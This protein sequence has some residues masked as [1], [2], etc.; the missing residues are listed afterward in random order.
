MK[1]KKNIIGGFSSWNIKILDFSRKKINLICIISLLIF[2]IVCVE[3]FSITGGVN[4]SNISVKVNEFRMQTV[5]FGGGFSFFTKQL[6]KVLRG[7]CY[8]G[9]YLIVNDIFGKKANSIS[10]CKIIIFLVLPYVLLEYLTGERFYLLTIAIY[11]LILYLI[12]SKKFLKNKSNF[13]TLIFLCL[14][15]VILVNI[16]S[17]SRSIVGRGGSTS[18]L[19]YL[20]SYFGN[21]VL[22]F[23]YWTKNFSIETLN[24]GLTTFSGIC[25]LLGDFGFVDSSKYIA[26]AYDF[27]YLDDTWNSIGNVYSC[28][29]YYL[30]DFGLAGIVIYPIIIALISGYLYYRKEGDKHAIS[31]KVLIYCLCGASLFLEG[32]CAGFLGNLV[33]IDFIVNFIII[34]FT[35]NYLSGT[36]PFRVKIIA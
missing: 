14:C 22:I 23:D 25:D 20:G 1:N 10:I 31:N 4:L 30:R 21:V 29:G 34:T 11:A 18:A 13:K 9:I 8:V 36:L 26:T 27:V 32:Y 12:F 3:Y 24:Y 19:T 6:I 15:F 16:F 2:I 28:F 17:S 35:L 33:S 7:F 5:F